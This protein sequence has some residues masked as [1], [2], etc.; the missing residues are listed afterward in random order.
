MQMSIAELTQRSIDSM[1][2]CAG[3]DWTGSEWVR[4][5]E[6]GWS[7]YKLVR[8]TIRHKLRSVCLAV[9]HKNAEISGRSRWNWDEQRWSTPC[10]RS[11]ADQWPMGTACARHV[12]S[13]HQWRHRPTSTADLHDALDIYRPMYTTRLWRRIEWL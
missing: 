5:G 9:K 3:R 11:L 8:R 10:S 6:V 13:D 1:M 2:W 4:W 12:T 7:R